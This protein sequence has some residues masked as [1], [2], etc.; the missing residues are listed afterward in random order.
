MFERLSNGACR[1]QERITGLECYHVTDAN[2]NVIL[3]VST[4]DHNCEPEVYAAALREAARWFEQVPAEKT[5][6]AA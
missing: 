5:L 2:G 6:R 4:I 1:W 3:V